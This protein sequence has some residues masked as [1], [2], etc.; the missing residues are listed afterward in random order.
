MPFKA[1]MSKSFNSERIFTVVLNYNISKEPYITLPKYTD[2]D[3]QTTN[4]F[5]GTKAGHLQPAFLLIDV[6]K[7]HRTSNNKVTATVLI[8]K[9]KTLV[10]VNIN[11]NNFISRGASA[12]L[13]Q[14][15]E[16]QRAQ[17]PDQYPRIIQHRHF[18][19]NGFYQTLNSG[20]KIN[21]YLEKPAGFSF[22]IYF[23]INNATFI[24]ENGS[25]RALMGRDLDYLGISSKI[26]SPNSS[27]IKALG[28]TKFQVAMLQQIYPNPEPLFQEP[29][30]NPEMP[31]ILPFQV[32][33]HNIFFDQMNYLTWLKMTHPAIYDGLC[34]A[35]NHTMLTPLQVEE[36][37][38]EVP[39]TQQAGEF[40]DDEEAAGLK[41]E[42]DEF[43][44]FSF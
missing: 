10:C 44:N 8:E 5:V 31:I 32:M 22:Y 4:Y 34:N 28:L 35:S 42:V 9:N 14:R 24:G 3:V 15:Y 39:E 19:K 6:I 43:S 17:N 20:V 33:L 30:A 21:V 27:D 16:Y 41:K 38:Q 37:P 23:S 18:S 12:K 2:Q 36:S 25:I 40:E 1:L 7:I 13:F 26:I 11:Q 29:E